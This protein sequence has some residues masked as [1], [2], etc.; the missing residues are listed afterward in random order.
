[1]N[2]EQLNLMM[3]ELGGIQHGIVFPDKETAHKAIVHLNSCYSHKGIHHFAVT[4][5]GRSVW[6][7]DTGRQCLE[8]AGLL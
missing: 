8:K 3:R 6:M 4:A 7:S 1:M 5:E 2:H